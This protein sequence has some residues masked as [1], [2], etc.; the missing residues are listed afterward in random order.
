VAGI[1]LS[2][3]KVP[4][5]SNNLKTPSLHFPCSESINQMP[6]P[7]TSEDNGDLSKYQSILEDAEAEFATKLAERGILRSDGLLSLYREL[8]AQSK[9]YPGSVHYLITA[10]VAGE[11]AIAAV[12]SGN[13]EALKVHLSLADLLVRRSRIGYCAPLTGLERATTILTSM[14]Q[15]VAEVQWRVAALQKLGAVYEEKYRLQGDAED[16]QQAYRLLQQAAGLADSPER[17][18]LLASAACLHFKDH[19]DSLESVLEI[20]IKDL[21]NTPVKWSNV[22]HERFRFIDARRFASGKSLRV[23]ELEALPQQRYV[24]LSYVWRGSHKEGT[25]P[26][27]MGTMTI[28]GAV[29][30]DPISIDVLTTV[31][32]CVASFAC[33]LLWIDGVCIVQD[34]PE[35]KAWQIQRMFDIYKHCKQC[36]V[37][38]GGLSRLVPLDEPTSWMHRAW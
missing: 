25:L 27:D 11:S 14:L 28:Q 29:G 35:D 32:K 23:I 34:S 13:E 4:G 33:E 9:E 1:T 24:A 37:L 20:P 15:R 12:T 10:I 2:E 8:E 26:P 3:P 5:H 21:P 18:L 6:V 22:T 31:C 30:A 17:G 38:P 19:P 7:P 36:L 16:L